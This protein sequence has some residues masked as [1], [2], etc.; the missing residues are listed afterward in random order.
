MTPLDLLIAAVERRAR[1]AD[2]IDRLL[3]ARPVVGDPC[4]LID[5][6]D[7]I[8][9]YRRALRGAEDDVQHWSSVVGGAR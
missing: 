3:D 4:A 5:R 8:D 9:W 2:A 1:C 6:E 7:A